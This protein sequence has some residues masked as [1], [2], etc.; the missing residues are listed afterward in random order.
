MHHYGGMA[1]VNRQV[2]IPPGQDQG[3]GMCT[4]NCSIAMCKKAGGCKAPNAGPPVCMH[5]K[6]HLG[7]ALCVSSSFTSTKRE[8]EARSLL[9]R[10]SMMAAL[11]TLP[12]RPMADVL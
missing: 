7:E 2:A 4:Q 3:L 1:G 11:A 12:Y 6:C 9:E 10:M 5:A 8:G